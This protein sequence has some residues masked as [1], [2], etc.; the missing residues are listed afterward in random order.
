[1][2]KVFATG[3]LLGITL[4]QL[5]F[6]RGEW[7]LQSHVIVVSHICA[8][9]I[10]LVFNTIYFAIIYVTS[11]LTSIAIYRLFFHR[12]RNFPGPRLAALTKLWHVWKCR[13]SRGHH[14][15]EAWHQ[16]YGPL[17]RTGPNEITIFQPDATDIVD[18]N[19]Y[20]NA[21]SDWYDLLYPRISSIFTRDKVVHDA[22]RKMW[23]NA[24]SPTL[25]AEYYSRFANQVEILVDLVSESSPNPIAI[26]TLIYCF[27]FDSMGDFGFGRDFGMM[28][29]KK[30]TDG[31]FYMRSALTLLGPFGPA[32]WIARLGFSFIPWLWKVGHWFKML[33]FADACI[34]ERLKRSLEKPDIFQFFLREYHRQGADKLSYQLLS[35]DTATLM[36]A[37]SDTTAPN[38]INYTDV[39]ALSQLPH[40]SGT[41]N[42]AMRLLPSVL[43][44]ST[45]ITRSKGLTVNGIF[46]PGGTKISTP[47]YSLGRL[48][49]AYEDPECFIPERWYSKPELVKDK[50]AFSPFGAGRTSCVGKPLA[51]AQLR[52]VASNL[53][54]RF[55]I[56]FAPGEGNGEG[57]ERDMRDQLTANPGELV[58][59]FKKK[60][61]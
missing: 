51:M 13:D 58:L 15:L 54:Y 2:W 34:D 5:L 43:T 21:R 59:V 30:L 24:L 18:G 56:K 10:L 46:I 20:G 28:K 27:A 60:D 41:I 61:K 9:F 53:L 11:L 38:N 42:E 23:E 19:Q 26:N 45:R 39:K 14:V 31:A 7:H 6:I 40:L 47:R 48:K 12:L 32:I 57:V 29:N 37:G 35:G 50:R 16:Q 52:L 8:L 22:R 49:S 17:V 55:N 3:S 36:V 1:M 25:L 4:H 44:F 33:A